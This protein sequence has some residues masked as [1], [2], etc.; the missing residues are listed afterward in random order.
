MRERT[1]RVA[2]CRQRLRT[3]GRC[4]SPNTLISVRGIERADSVATDAHKWLN[5]PYDCGVIFLRGRSGA[6][7]R[8]VA[9]RR[10][11]CC[12]QARSAIRTN[13]F[14]R[15]RAAPAR[16][17]STRHCARSAG[18]ASPRLSSATAVRPDASAKPCA[19]RDTKC[20]TMS[21]SIRFSSRLERR[22]RP[23]PR[24]RHPER[25][26]VLVRGHGVARPYGYADQRQ[27]LVDER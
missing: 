19:P 13:L 15:N 26:H 4:L 14:R 2:A 7:E 17:R 21:C 22:N 27:Q 25:R 18:V 6:S 8:D 24:W 23:R 3:L 5:V 10:L 11:H 16:S 9:R 12:H 1:R 20:S